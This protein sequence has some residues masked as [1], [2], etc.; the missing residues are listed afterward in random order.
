MVDIYPVLTNIDDKVSAV[1]EIYLI[2]E[3][4]IAWCQIPSA[5]IW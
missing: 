4:L 1:N 2:S 5:Q 3:Y